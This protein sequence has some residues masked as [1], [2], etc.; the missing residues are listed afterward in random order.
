[1]TDEVACVV[2]L[3]CEG[4][5]DHRTAS[6]LSD[7][8]LCERVAW[9]EPST[10]DA[11]RRYRGLHDS[12]DFVEWTVAVKE[13]DTRRIRVHGH[14]NE[15]PRAPDA[16]MAERALLVLAMLGHRPDAVILVRDTDKDSRRREG[17]EQARTAKR[18]P[19]VVVIGVAETKRECWV[20]AGY[21]PRSAAE[22][23]RLTDARK[24]LGFDPR[25][26]AQHLTASGGAKRDAKR[27][28]KALLGDDAE[29]ERTCLE[30]T[31]LDA[32]KRRGAASGLA[33][34]LSELEQHLV[35][36]FDPSRRPPASVADGDGD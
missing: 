19:F 15:A 20:L 16:V 4:A 12:E 31:A 36:F 28:L 13:A 30:A 22:H 34:Y 24:E 5:A 33:A 9:I 3:L 11:Y 14:R 17:F 7:R 27:V 32:L 18:W 2:T 29:R 25:D 23:Q 6:T 8:V 1:M 10:I 35:P 21:E 26:D